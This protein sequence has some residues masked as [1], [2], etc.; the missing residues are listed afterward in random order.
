MNSINSFGIKPFTPLNL[1]PTGSKP[2]EVGNPVASES[3]QTQGGSVP[4]LMMQRISFSTAPSEAP[5][6][7]PLISPDATFPNLE[8]GTAHK[9]CTTQGSKGYPER[10]LTGPVAWSQPNASYK[11]TKFTHAVVEA[12]PKWADPADAESARLLRPSAKFE[13]YEGSVATSVDGVTPRNP[14]GRTGLEERGLLGKWGANFAADPIVTRVN[15]ESG[16]LEMIAI[17]RTDTKQW[18]IPGGMVDFGE[19]VSATLSRELA[20]EALGKGAEAEEVKALEH[21]FKDMFATS[22][23]EVYAGYVDDPR[24]T[25][26]AWMETKAVHLHLSGADAQ[27]NLVA[28]DDAGKVQWMEL[29]NENLSKLYAS[30][31]DFVGKAVQDWQA[32]NNKTVMSD[33][34]LR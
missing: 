26:N 18:A 2:T 1:A 10:S 28:G 6:L 24:N 13:T 3:F 5:E 20:E 31:G 33:G 23:H 22:G 32:A 17:E 21:K 8:R 4:G 12:G 9:K 29:T 19:P 14:R 34:S 7:Q 16:K 11:P 30:H 25:D 15:P 27:I